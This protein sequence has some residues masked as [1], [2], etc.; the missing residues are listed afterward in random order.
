MAI[1]GCM[2]GAICGKKPRMSLALIRATRVMATLMLAHSL[3]AAP[4]QAN[5][6]ELIVADEL[7]K[8]ILAGVTG[9]AAAVRIDGRTVFYNAGYADGASK[10]P[11]DSD[12]LFNLASVSKIFDVTLL[13]LLAVNGELSFDDPVAKYVR[14]LDN[15]GNASRITLRQLVTFS[16]GF[17]VT[18]DNPPWWPAEHFTLPKFLRHLQKWKRD[19]NHAPGRDYIY[20]H[21]G[22]MLLHVALER[23]FG[24]PYAA[25][26]E[27]RLLRPL[28]LPSTLLPLRGAGEV[29]NL[30]P[31]LK[32]RAVQ[33][34]SGEGRPIGKPGNMQ[35][36][37]YWP[38]TGQMFSS[39]SDMARL[40]AAHL[41][42]LPLNP[43]L[44]RAI[45]MTHQET[46][47]IR[48]NVMQAQAWEVHHLALP[49]IDKNGGLNNTTTYIGMIPDKRLGV[50]ILMN[51]GNT[52][53][54]DFG[55]AILLRL[56][57]LAEAAGQTQ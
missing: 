50:V 13:S 29:G 40:L 18:H 21:A 24:M 12:C 57:A 8:G 46:L 9:A 49:I 39:A 11:M 32:L 4:A 45:K 36:Y 14:E 38:G 52:D 17:S 43:A 30:G 37:Y 16:S 22:F 55:H 28:D 6:I 7:A 41:G 3:S 27:R 5:D 35:G 34:Y 20:S 2:S 10:R 44:Q 23:R 31:A 48:P 47:V 54:R 26:L 25:L 33:G 19:P 53:G 1:V 15:G 51:R 56:A 42:E